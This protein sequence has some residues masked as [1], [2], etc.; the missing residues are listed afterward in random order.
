MRCVTCVGFSHE[1]REI[2][3]EIGWLCELT[4]RGCLKDLY[5]K[6]RMGNVLVG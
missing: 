1:S 5:R 3:N 2:E 4:N 6:R